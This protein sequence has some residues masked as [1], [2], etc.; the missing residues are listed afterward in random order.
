MK[1]FLLLL[2]VLVGLPVLAALAIVGDVLVTA[3]QSDDEP[4]DAAIVLGAAVYDYTPTP[5][6]EERLRHGVELYNEG[7]VR[8]LVMTGGTGPGDSLAEAE[9]GEAYAL[10]AGVPSSAIITE[11]QSATTKENLVFSRPRSTS[12]GSAGCCGHRSAPHAARLADGDRSG[13]RRPSSPTPT[14]RC[15]RSLDT[16]LPMLLREAYF[17]IGYL[18]SGNRAEADCLTLPEVHRHFPAMFRRDVTRQAHERTGELMQSY[19]DFKPVADL[20]GKIA[21]LKVAGAD[22]P[23]SVDRRRSGRLSVRAE[24]ALTDIYRRLTPWQKTQVAR[25]PQRPHFRTM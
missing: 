23:G 1:R 16:Q 4:A 2:G 3:T 11:K 15:Y 5:V 19:L 12:W 6:F 24:E 17:N 22:R 7:R 25:H 9:V 8:Y 21:E 14:S 13:H 20:E 10:N 18:L